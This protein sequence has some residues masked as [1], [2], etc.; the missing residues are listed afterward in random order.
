MRKRM[1]RILSG[2]LV[3]V[4][5][6]SMGSVVQAEDQRGSAA[7]KPKVEAEAIAGQEEGVKA[8]ESMGST[9]TAKEITAKATVEGTIP[10]NKIATG[11]EKTASF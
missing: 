8:L 11:K 1:S 6:M 10:L 7:G 2:L 3:S 4:L 5:V 9:E